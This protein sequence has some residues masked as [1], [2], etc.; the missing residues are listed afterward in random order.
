MASAF[1]TALVLLLFH[2][3][4]SRAATTV[5]NIA[6][7]KNS[8]LFIKSDGSLW[9]MGYNAVGN[10]GD[11]TSSDTNRPVQIISNNVV[12]IAAAGNHSPFIKSD[13][14]LWTMG[15]N[16]NGGLGDGFATGSTHPE[17]IVPRPQPVLTAGIVSK[18]NV[19]L[20]ATCEFAGKFSLLGSTNATLPLDQ[21]TAIQTNSIISRAFVSNNFNFAATVTNVSGSNAQQFYILQSQ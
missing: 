19:Q 17:Q 4:A 8:T 2:A 11:G 10:L 16:A 7:G 5:T 3:V 9:G 14:S 13:G 20:F 21:W 18:T 15:D 6:A 12:A 1:K